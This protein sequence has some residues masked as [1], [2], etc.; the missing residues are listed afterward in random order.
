M[1][2]R[3][4][5]IQTPGPLPRWT[6]RLCLIAGVRLRA[7][8]GYRVRADATIE[9]AEYFIIAMAAGKLPAG[10]R[11]LGATSVGPAYTAIWHRDPGGRWTFRI[12]GE[13]FQCCN[14]YSGS[15]VDEAIRGEIARTGAADARWWSR[16]PTGRCGGRSPRHRR[17]SRA[18]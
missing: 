9:M 6:E 5:D 2:A 11:V 8:V 12:T 16:P 10:T 3:R 17:R 4:P 15:A 1:H 7:L 18:C 13:L 14:R